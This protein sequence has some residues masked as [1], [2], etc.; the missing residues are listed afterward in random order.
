MEETTFI[1]KVAFSKLQIRQSDLKE[2]LI[3][4]MK[5]LIPPPQVTETPDDVTEH[6]NGEELLE[7][8]KRLQKEEEYKLYDRI[9]VRQLSMEE[10]SDMDTDGQLIPILDEDM[11][12]H[13]L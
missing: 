1:D 10:E 6:T 8:E 7:A 4:V 2:E 12:I 13:K 3:E 5:S 11:N 9:Y